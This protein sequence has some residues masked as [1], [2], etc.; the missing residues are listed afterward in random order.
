MID[1]LLWTLYIIIG[2][3]LVSVIGRYMICPPLYWIGA[4]LDE[5][6]TSCMNGEGWWF[7]KRVN[8]IKDFI[9]YRYNTDGYS[10]YESIR[11]VPILGI[12]SCLLY[13][14][15]IIIATIFVF[16]LQI[17]SHIIIPI[18]DF[19]WKYILSPTF[20]FIYNISIKFFELIR[21]NKIAYIIQNFNKCVIDKFMNTK[22]R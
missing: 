19:I 9:K 17:I 18:M 1:F 22:V 20:K 5:F 8:T 21:L 2:G 4:I 7:E 11:W 15:F 14:L 10:Q 6:N 3:I 13:L 16:I 12:I